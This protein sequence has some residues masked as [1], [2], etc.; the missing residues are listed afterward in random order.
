MSVFLGPNNSLF[1]LDYDKFH[2]KNEFWNTVIENKFGITENKV[3]N[4]IDALYSEIDAIF[5]DY[6]A[7]H[8]K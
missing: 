5:E 3:T 8:K 1:Q 2:D 6:N 7:S 4:A